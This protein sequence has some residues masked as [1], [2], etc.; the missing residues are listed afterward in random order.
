MLTDSEATTRAVLTFLLEAGVSQLS[1]PGPTL[2]DVYLSL[3][4][5]RGMAVR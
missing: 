5:D 1:T 2:A 3:I 4:E